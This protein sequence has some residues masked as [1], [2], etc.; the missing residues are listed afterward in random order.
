MHYLKERNFHSRKL[1]VH[2]KSSS[3]AILSSF[4]RQKYGDIDYWKMKEIRADREKFNKSVE[5]YI[6]IS[7]MEP[8]SRRNDLKFFF[9]VHKDQHRDVIFSRYGSNKNEK[10]HPSKYVIELAV[11][12]DH[13]LYEILGQTFPR[14]TRESISSVVLAM[15]DMV[16]N[17]FIR[18]SKFVSKD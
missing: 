16:G 6:P 9:P 5:E 3:N 13:K 18:Y 1:T 10:D 15:I 11:F 14:D 2:N 12:I 8:T 7:N 4:I 17:I